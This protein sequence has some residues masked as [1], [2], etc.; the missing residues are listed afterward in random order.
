MLSQMNKPMLSMS[1]LG[2]NLVAV[3]LGD[4]FGLG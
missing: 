3:E 4:C 2:V 1:L